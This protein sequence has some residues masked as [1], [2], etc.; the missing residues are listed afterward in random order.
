MCLT[1]RAIIM[2]HKDSTSD[3]EPVHRS[4]VV[5][6]VAAAHCSLLWNYPCLFIQL[7]WHPDRVYKCVSVS[8]CVAQ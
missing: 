5:V 2:H 6:V 3:D 1:Q 8:A 7:I 4:G